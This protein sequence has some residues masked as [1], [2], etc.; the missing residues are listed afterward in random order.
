MFPVQPSFESLPHGPVPYFHRSNQHSIPIAW[1]CKVSVSI[2]LDWFYTPDS[3]HNYMIRRW[4]MGDAA[5]TVVI[6]PYSMDK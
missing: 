3:L 1:H 2:V 6:L 4:R 5:D